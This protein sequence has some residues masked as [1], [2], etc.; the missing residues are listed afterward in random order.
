MI[1]EPWNKALKNDHFADWLLKLIIHGRILLTP[2]WEHNCWTLTKEVESCFCSQMVS[3]PRHSALVDLGCYR[4]ADFV[5][6][7][8]WGVLHNQHAISIRLCEGQRLV[9]D[10]YCFRKRQRTKGESARGQEGGVS[11]K[12][13]MKRRR[14]IEW[15]KIKEAMRRNNREWK[16]SKQIREEGWVKK[17]WLEDER[18][19]MKKTEAKVKRKRENPIIFGLKTPNDLIICVGHVLDSPHL[20]FHFCSV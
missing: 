17:E 6:R 2:P 3:H 12:G 19:I 20:H 7:R 8:G 4:E 14:F 11:S 13:S 1:I 15:E 9:K 16:E 10:G 5:F 18:Q